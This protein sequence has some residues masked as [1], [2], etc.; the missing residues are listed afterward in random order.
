M[1]TNGTLPPDVLAGALQDSVH[2]TPGTLIATTK[3]EKPRR[4][5]KRKLRHF[6]FHEPVFGRP[7]S[8]EP[9]AKIWKLDAADEAQA[10]RDGERALPKHKVFVMVEPGVRWGVWMGTGKG[11]E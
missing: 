4:P 7:G 1:S 9:G 8:T 2:E 11:G 3:I 10:L 6:T 5:R